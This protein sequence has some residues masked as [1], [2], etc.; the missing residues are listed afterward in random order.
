VVFNSE[1]DVAA[2]NAAMVATI[3]MVPEI[4]SPPAKNRHTLSLQKS[5]AA[6]KLDAIFPFNIE[7]K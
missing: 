2:C 1:V 6:A 4:R 5:D 3:A 7:A